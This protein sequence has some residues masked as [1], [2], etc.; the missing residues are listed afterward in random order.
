MHSLVRLRFEADETEVK[1][2]WRSQTWALDNDSSLVKLV[3]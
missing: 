3:E 1:A 2:A